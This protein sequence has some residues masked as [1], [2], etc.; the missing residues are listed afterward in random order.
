M[1]GKKRRTVTHR[2]PGGITLELKPLP[3]AALLMVLAQHH[4]PQP[5][6]ID[7]EYPGGVH[8]REP[9]PNDPDYKVSHDLWQ[10]QH[11]A[12]LLRLC[13]AEGVERALN[14]DGSVA[15]PDRAAIKTNRCMNGSDL[16][17][18]EI[19]LHWL[20]TVIGNTVNGFID[21]VMGQTEP[22]SAGLEEAEA[23]FRSDG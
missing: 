8:V 9:N 22:T 4:E 1:M 16:A 14:P 12:G 17:P 15:T 13:I 5:P 19:Y 11:T 18:G 6:M 3:Q 2:C 20:A 23:S 7:V 21:L 10:A